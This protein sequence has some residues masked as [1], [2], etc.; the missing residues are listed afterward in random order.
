MA[1]LADIVRHSANFRFKQRYERYFAYSVLASF[2]AHVAFNLY[3]PDLSA[4]FQVREE[5]TMEA[6]DLPPEVII[7]PP[8]KP[9]AKPSVPMEAP[10]ELDEDITIEETTPPP[11]DLIPEVP[12]QEVKDEAQEFLMV[13]EVVAKIKYMPPKPKIPPYI[14]RARV[15]V[16]TLVRFFVDEKGNVDP[17][18]TKIHTSSGYP[19]LDDIAVEWA[20]QM[21]FHPALNRGEP[22]KMQ[23]SI[24]I[25]WKSN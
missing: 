1:S 24:P 15:D 4:G 10:E 22:V 17:N 16:T 19:E 21:K 8:P 23:M 2:F 6:M 7:P 5:K 9:L 12:V 14:A 13:A 25:Q 3:F 11:P 18:R 20:K